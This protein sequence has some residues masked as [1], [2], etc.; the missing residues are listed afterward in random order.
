VSTRNNKKNEIQKAA[1]Q[2]FSDFGTDAVSTKKIAAAAAVSEGLI[3][4]HFQNKEGLIN[5]LYEKE[6]EAIQT[7]AKGLE[8]LSHPKVI[9]S[10]IL[11]IPFLIKEKH[12]T[13]YKWHI[14]MMGKQFSH[15]NILVPIITPKLKEAFMALEVKNITAEIETFWI[16][17][18][19]FV[20]A[21]I[22]E[23]D[24]NFISIY[25][26]LKEKYKI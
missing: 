1:L 13:F 21:L 26:C 6:V 8:D 24:L 2:L 5:F 17:F 23:P 25:N 16:V 12:F 19:G 20:Q 10:E 15:R 4:R 11:S 22:L 3:F 9:L 14:G 18:N 7:V